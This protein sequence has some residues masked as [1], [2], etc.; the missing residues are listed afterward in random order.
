MMNILTDPIFLD[1]GVPLI[2]VALSIFLKFVTRN[3]Q[4][5]SS[6]KEDLAFGIDLTIS[7]A[8]AHTSQEGRSRSVD[9]N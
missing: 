9:R 5:A 7:G 6:Q 8:G 3:D 2:T 1:F 4:H